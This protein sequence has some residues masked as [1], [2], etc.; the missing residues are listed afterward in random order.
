MTDFLQKIAVTE[1]QGCNAPTF[2]QRRHSAE[3]VK[4]AN[5]I[6]H[7]IPCR[8]SCNFLF[9]RMGLIARRRKRRSCS[10][11]ADVLRQMGWIRQPVDEN[12]GSTI[13]K[14][15]SILFTLKQYHKRVFWTFQK[16]VQNTLA[17][18]PAG[19]QG[20][21]GAGRQSRSGNVTSG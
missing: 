21:E 19:R 18:S 15:F 12:R 11:T 3:A 14:S 8:C 9:P 5:F 2:F 1:T 13:S 17:A 6:L 20:Q 4:K 10:D 16:S 7:V